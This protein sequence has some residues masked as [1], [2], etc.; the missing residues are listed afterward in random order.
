[1]STRE[2]VQIPD[3]RDFDNF[4]MEC[5]SDDGW[6]QTYSKSGIVVWIQI[7]EAERSLHKIKVSSEAWAVF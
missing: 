7:L 5:N 2:S 6:S 3:D 4:Q 1:M